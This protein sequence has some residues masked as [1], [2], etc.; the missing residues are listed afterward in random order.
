MEKEINEL[1]LKIAEYKNKLDLVTDENIRLCKEIEKYKENSHVRNSRNAGR[2]PIN[3]ELKKIAVKLYEQ[4]LSMRSIAK[5]LNIATGSV[6]KIIN[7]HKH[8]DKES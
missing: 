1:K 5:E 2:K 7:E 8:Y 4:D 3:D 6:H